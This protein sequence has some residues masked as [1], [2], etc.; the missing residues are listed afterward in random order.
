MKY[1]DYF[2]YGFYGQDMKSYKYYMT[3]QNIRRNKNVK[4]SAMVYSTG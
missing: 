2:F 1:D 3:G 4:Q